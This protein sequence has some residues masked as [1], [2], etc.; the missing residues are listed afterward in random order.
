LLAVR[1]YQADFP[2]ANPVVDPVFAGVRCSGY[3]ASLLVVE[4]FPPRGEPTRRKADVRK[5]RPPERSNDPTHVENINDVADVAGWGH[6]PGFHFQ[7]SVS[8]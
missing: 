3:A 8:V 5:Q 1:I 4:P 6:C 7:F 2:G